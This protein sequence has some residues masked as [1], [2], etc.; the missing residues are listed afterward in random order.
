M[1]IYGVGDVGKNKTFSKAIIGPEA[2]GK[3]CKLTTSPTPHATSVAIPCIYDT[4]FY[5][6]S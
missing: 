4:A 1:N 6:F 5:E 2:L 3:S